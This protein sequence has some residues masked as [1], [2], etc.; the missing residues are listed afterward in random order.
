M[1]DA[2]PEFKLSRSPIF[3]VDAEGIGEARNA[4]T[5]ANSKSERTSPNADTTELRSL[6]FR[7]RGWIYFSP[8]LAGRDRGALAARD[9][10]V[11]AKRAMIRGFPR[12]NASVAQL[13]ELWFCKPGVVGSSPTASSA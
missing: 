6:A 11:Q 12:E 13:A 10:A 7:V 1:G 9:I 8:S 4:K 3:E 2:D 5:T